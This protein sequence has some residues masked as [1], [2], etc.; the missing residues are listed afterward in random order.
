MQ[1]IVIYGTDG[2]DCMRE[3][4]RI[5][6]E[7]RGDKLLIP[8][9]H[10]RALEAYLSTN[11]PRVVIVQGATART[12]LAARDR[13]LATTLTLVIFTTNDKTAARQAAG[14]SHL[15]LKDTTQ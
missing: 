12:L 15:T 13:L 6:Q 1:H 10:P 9:V 2:F 3:A 5:G 7:H 4:V 11:C 8:R 14:A